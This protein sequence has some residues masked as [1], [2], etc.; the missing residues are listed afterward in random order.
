M[1]IPASII[2][3]G[4]HSERPRS[5]KSTVAA[6]L[7]RSVGGTVY[8]LADGIRAVARELGLAAAADAVGDAKDVPLDQL[9]GRTP[10]EVLIQIGET[11][12]AM[13]GREYWLRRLLDRIAD[14]AEVKRRQ[15]TA[16]GVSHVAVIDDV[17]RKEEGQGLV[18]D[19]ATVCTI[20]RDGVPDVADINGWR[21]GTAYTFRND[22][23]P[24]ECGRRIWDRAK[25][26]RRTA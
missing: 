22:G 26:D 8:S 25:R 7:A 17:R 13:H 6:E 24:A 20:V 10:R 12:C 21:S 9:D 3:I 5:G 4:L 11:R 16:P 15:S 2:V 1:R 18:D 23:T 19:G 14:D